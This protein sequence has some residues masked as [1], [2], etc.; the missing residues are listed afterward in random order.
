MWKIFKTHRARGTSSFAASLHS[1]IWKT[2]RWVTCKGKIK[3][4][5][6]CDLTLFVKLRE[7]CQHLT[8]SWEWR[9][10]TWKASK[11]SII[12]KKEAFQNSIHLKNVSKVQRLSNMNRIGT[13]FCFI[14]ST[15][16]VP[17]KKIL[18]GNKTCSCSKTNDAV[19]ETSN[20]SGEIKSCQNPLCLPPRSI[21]I[22]FQQNFFAFYVSHYLN[23]FFTVIFHRQS[24]YTTKNL[25]QW[26]R[27]SS[28]ISSHLRIIMRFIRATPTMKLWRE[29][30][31]STTRTAWKSLTTRCSRLARYHRV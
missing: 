11:A 28:G 29:I 5:F 22:D 26:L 9:T 4:G 1:Q 18:S 2:T 8:R 20:H 3:R 30:F 21:C 23:F 14:V 6:W 15:K 31:T 19:R 24:H 12:A 17:E 16:L 13:K 25:K 10:R 7:I 27:N